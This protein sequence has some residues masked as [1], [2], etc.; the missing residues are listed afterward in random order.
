MK[1]ISDYHL[2]KPTKRGEGG[3]S[4]GKK[5]ASKELGE[6]VCSFDNTFMPSSKMAG[7]GG[8]SKKKDQGPSSLTR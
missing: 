2:K 1:V 3:E 6:K 4:R 5:S 7:K 8:K